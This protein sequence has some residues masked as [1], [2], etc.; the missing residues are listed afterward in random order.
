MKNKALLLIIGFG[1]IFSLQPGLAAERNRRLTLTQEEVRAIAEKRMNLV[2]LHKTMSKDQIVDDLNSKVE[3][4]TQELLDRGVPPEKVDTLRS[5]LTQAR[6]QLEK[7]EKEDIIAAEQGDNRIEKPD[8]VYVGSFDNDGNLVDNNGNIVY[9]LFSSKPEFDELP[10]TG[11]LIKSTSKCDLDTCWLLTPF[12]VASFA[13][14][15]VT[16]PFR[17]LVYALTPEKHQDN[18]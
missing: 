7:L 16:L 4:R 1:Y 17:A 9:H 2:N 15:V 13:A 8:V 11:A 3:Q 6:G 14:D 5:N 18:R 12:L 10:V